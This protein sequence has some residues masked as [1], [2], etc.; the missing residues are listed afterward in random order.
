MIQPVIFEVEKQIPQW[1]ADYFELANAGNCSHKQ[2][3]Y[4]T[5]K[6][7]V[8]KTFGKFAGYDLQIIEKKCWSCNGTGVFKHYH[9]EFSQRYLISQEPCWRCKG[10]IYET[11]KISLRRYILNGKL[12]HIPCENFV[13]M[14]YYTNEI[15]GVIVHEQVDPNKALRAFIILLWIYNKAEFY[16]YLTSFAAHEIQNK[17]SWIKPLLQS[18]FKKDNTNDELPF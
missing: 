17:T 14:T 6:P 12:Y 18:L 2:S 5:I 15:K 11:K 13:S 1:I 8:L 4:S 3:F 10:G 9:Y 16:N 7:H